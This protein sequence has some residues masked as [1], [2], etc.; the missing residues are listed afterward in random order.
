MTL[1]ELFA[2]HHLTPDERW[3]LVV[4]LA[5]LRTAALLRALMEPSE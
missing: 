1:D 4:H 5:T 2:E 3:A